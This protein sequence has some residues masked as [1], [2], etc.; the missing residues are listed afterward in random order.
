[1][2]GVIVG[3]VVPVIVILIVLM[4]LL[5][6]FLR[7][8]RSTLANNAEVTESR[9]E[10]RPPTYMEVEL[11]TSAAQRITEYEEVGS[12]PVIVSKR[13]EPEY[14]NGQTMNPYE[15]L[16]TITESEG[17]DHLYEGLQ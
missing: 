14:E 10:D 2:T 1:L 16:G 8:Q 9:Q 13:C 4:V 17:G 5:I 3:S 6:I 7:R 12:I 15:S 11:Q